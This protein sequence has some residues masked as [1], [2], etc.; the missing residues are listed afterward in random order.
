LKVIALIEDSW[1]GHRPTYLKLF[2]KTLLELGHQVIT[3]CP[4]P[5]ELEDWL[6]K[7]CKS[8]PEQYKIFEFCQPPSTRFPLQQLHSIINAVN[9]WHEAKL[10]LDHAFQQLG[11]AP[12]LVFFCVL[13]GYLTI[14]LNHYLV[15]GIFPYQW[16]GLYFH[17]HHM[18]LRTRLWDF[19]PNFVQPHAGLNSSRCCVLAL[20]DEGISHRFQTWLPGK[21]V[22]IFPDCIDA[23]DP[24]F[25]FSL[26]Q[27]IKEK[28]QGRKIIGL[29]GSQSKRKGI[30]TLV[31]VAKK[32][33][34]EP[35]FFLFAGNLYPKTFTRQ[36]HSQLL[37]I[38]SLNYQNCFFYWE[39]IPEEPRFNALVSICDILFAA[40]ENFP[41]SS[42]MLHK[43][44]KFAKPIIVSKNY[45]MAQRVEK[46][47]LGVS[48]N[49]GNVGEC[50]EAIHLL[51]S[52]TLNEPKFQSYLDTHAIDQLSSAFQGVLACLEN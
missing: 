6:K 46:F 15:D 27:H 50:I 1:T 20:L 7:H 52:C 49:E 24:D 3:F 37:E 41:H 13:D 43:A 16:S 23:S 44:A 35:F 18:R 4:K 9:L 34:S 8:E 25:S 45:C 48:I 10:I 47:N 14:G 40:Y 42:N 32:M 11:K 31:E 19:L 21:K 38:I 26:I 28:A 22:I 36:E 29:L 39:V 17:P 30:F 51:D 12:D 2:N 5:Q 33:A